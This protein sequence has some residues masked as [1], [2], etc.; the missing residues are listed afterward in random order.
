MEKLAFEYDDSSGNYKAYSQG[1]TILAERDS[2]A[3]NPW[4]A[5]DSMPPMIV[6]YDG[7][8]TEYGNFPEPLAGTSDAWIA[9][10]W[11]E[12]CK[13][14]DVSPESAAERKSADGYFRIADA[15]R[16]LIDE[17]LSDAKPGS[18]GGS[19]GDWLELLESL[20]RL[21]GWPVLNTCSRGYCQ[22]DY[23][24]LLLVWSPDFDKSTGNKWLR[25]KATKA[26]ALAD[27]AGSAKT[28]GAWAWG[29]V[30]GY[31]IESPDGEHLDSCWGF[32]GSDFDESGLLEAAQAALDW[33]VK[34]RRER[35]AAKLK[36]LIR[37]R[38]PLH[39]RGDILEGVN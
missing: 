34:G 21:R 6:N 18:Y 5:W 26:L 20:F 15:K 24:D 2:D 16:D 8:L 14:F 37:A 3:E 19:R 35:R 33:N 25:S 12:L 28:Y 27:L 29:D 32:Y 11:R 38:V 1:F 23:A 17:W 31:V 13:L 30:Y 39:L 22:S 10:H 7:R 36:E 9:R 4:Q